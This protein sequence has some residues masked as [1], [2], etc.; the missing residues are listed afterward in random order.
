MLR[1][2]ATGYRDF[3]STP[4]TLC[5]RYNWII[6]CVFEGNLHPRFEPP[7]PD[8]KVD[9][10]ANFFII[11]PQ[12]RYVIVAETR[13]C[14]RAVFHFS[15]VPEIL[16]QAVV[17][18]GCLSR[19]LGP[20]AVAEVRA[21]AASIQ[22]DFRRPTVLSELRYEMAVL[23]LTLI[24][25]A[26]LDA[27]PVNPLYNLSRDRVEKAL[28]WYSGHMA[29]SPTLYEVARNVHVSQTHLR[30]HFYD[31]LGRSPKAVFSKLRM[32]K[33]TQLLVNSSL[34]LD[35]I[36]EHCGFNTASDFC[37]AFKG[38]FNV[39]PNSWRRNVNSAGS[40]PRDFN[41]NPI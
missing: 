14:D 35:Q 4:D 28:A 16:Q 34:T 26:H 20:R 41:A 1:S 19:Q 10:A 31:R 25:L 5:V 17:P 32:Q 15:E 36:A 6:L 9:R 11:P 39:T 40:E 13:K 23:Q 3:K 27:Q 12:T 8:A 22:E 38:H 29:E 30:R 33:A 2:L 18:N 37:R 7:L 21:I 24:A